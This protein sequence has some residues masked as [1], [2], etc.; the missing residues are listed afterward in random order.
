[1]KFLIIGCGSIGKRHI[2]NLIKIGIHKE[3]IYAVDTRIDRQNEVS[4]FGVS[5]TYSEIPLEVLKDITCGIIC[6]PTSMHIQHGQLLADNNVH[7][8]I[9]KPICS[10]LNGIEKLLNTIKKNNLTAMTAYIFRFT[11]AVDKIKN[12]LNDNLI[13]KILYFRGEFSEYLPDWHPYE[14]YR[15]FYMAEKKLGGGSILDQ[16]HIM[17]LSHYL[18]GNFK[19]VMAYNS[20]I[21]S[22]EINADDIAEL[23]ITLDNNIISSIHTD[24]FGRNHKKFLEIKGEKGNVIWDF[25]KKEVHLYQSE[26]K[27]TIIFEKLDEDF[28]ESYLREIN[29]F[30]ECVKNSS[31]SISPI[32]DGIDTMKLILAS[33]KSHSTNTRV[34]V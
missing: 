16:C 17:D 28:N 24:I 4:E 13:G 1:M 2:R 34:E 11:E 6:S 26:E 22:L 30:I 27:K 7:L 15:K 14:D 19:S 20:K 3:N 9:E 31:K 10:N 29:H 32:E 5:N 25:Y 18:C 12:I 21:S 33:E 8:L 23:I